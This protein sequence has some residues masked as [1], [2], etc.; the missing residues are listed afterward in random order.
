MGKKETVFKALDEDKRIVFAEVYAPNRPDAD[1]EFMDADGI[2]EMSYK[3]MRELKLRQVDRQHDNEAVPE[4]CVVESFIAREDDPLFISGAWVV[5]VHIPDDETWGMIKEGEINGFSM[6]AIV[7]KTPM[8][9]TLSIPP[10]VSGTTMEASDHCHIF[11]VAYDADGNFLGGKTD[12]VNGHYHEIKR[13]TVTE[14]SS[15]HSHRF[16]HV[17]DLEIIE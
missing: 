13:G 6:E 9:V 10:V 5:G 15:E 3:F 17:E 4:V 14:E 1:G 8:E 2:R 11:N 12:T 7:I 16:S